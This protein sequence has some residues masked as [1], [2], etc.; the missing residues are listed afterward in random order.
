MPAGLEEFYAQEL[1][2]GSCAKLATSEDLKFYRS[3]SLQCADLTVPLSYDDPTGATITLK[4]LRKPA[5]QTGAADRV[6][7]HQSRWAG[8]SGVEYAGALGAYGVAA[9]LNRSFD[10]VGFDPRG[11]ASS[12]PAVRCQ[13][14][15]ER[16]ET[17]ATTA[18]TRTQQDVDAA[19]ALAE[20]LPGCATLTGVGTRG[21]TG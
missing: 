15:K 1:D 8:G 7:D 12:V 19:N 9:E 18:R 5:T 21:S 17:R 6:G 20:Q 4:V 3:A 2:W 13:T 14:D 11:V 10:F 16:D